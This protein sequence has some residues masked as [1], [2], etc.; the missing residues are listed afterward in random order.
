MDKIFCVSD[1]KFGRVSECNFIEVN[2]FLK[3]H[4]NFEVKK[5]TPIDKETVIITVGTIKK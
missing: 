2:S 4:P 1:D 3:N 5:I